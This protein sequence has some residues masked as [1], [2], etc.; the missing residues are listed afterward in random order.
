MESDGPDPVTHGY[1]PEQVQEIML[2]ANE[3][4]SNLMLYWY[5]IEPTFLSFLGTDSEYIQVDMPTPSQK[6]YD[7]R[8]VEF[9]CAMTLK[10]RIGKADGICADE[11]VILKK[12]MSSS[13]YEMSSNSSKPVATLSP[14]YGALDSFTISM[15]Q[16][17]DMFGYFQRNTTNTTNPRDAICSWAFDHMEYLKSFIPNSYPRVVSYQYGDGPLFYASISLGTITTFLVLC[18]DFLVHRRRRL[19]TIINAQIDFL[20]L[21]ISGSLLIALGAIVVVVPVSNGT[22][23]A[24]IWLVNIGYS[25]E[26]VPMIVKVAAIQKRI[27]STKF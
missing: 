13:A 24:G 20:W 16:L 12:L 9:S 1:P 2:A 11:E 14:A 27:S 21:L 22:C 18:T 5:N 3:T 8:P 23:V 17:N 15:I 26:L 25:L 4:K 6:C 7:S 10:E 19:Q